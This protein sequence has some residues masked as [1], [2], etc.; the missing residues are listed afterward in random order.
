MVTFG[1]DFAV[2]VLG[3]VLSELDFELLLQPASAIPAIATAMIKRRA[4][5]RPPLYSCVPNRSPSPAKR[6]SYLP[7]MREAAVTLLPERVVAVQPCEHAA[8]LLCPR[9]RVGR[10]DAADELRVTALVHAVLRPG[11]RIVLDAC[12]FGDR[13][14]ARRVEEADAVAMGVSGEVPGDRVASRDHRAQRFAVVGI[15]AEVMIV[16]LVGAGIPRMMVTEH[17]HRR[18]RIRGKVVEPRD[19]VGGDAPVLRTGPHRV[20][21]GKGDTG[22]LDRGGRVHRDLIAPHRG[23]GGPRGVHS[24]AEFGGRRAGSPGLPPRGRGGGGGP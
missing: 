11:A 17:E 19:L 14:P 12:N 22:E 3:V 10:A 13:N 5:T 4:F 23:G 6:I 1:I 20:E 24:G 2:V 9:H 15:D 7:R 8:S 21:H 18:G 16:A